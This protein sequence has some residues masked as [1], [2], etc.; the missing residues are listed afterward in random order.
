M[1]K[2]SITHF[3]IALLALVFT[4]SA[5]VKGEFDVPPINIPEFEG[6]ANKT[7]ADLKASYAWVLDSIEEDIIIT[8]KVVGNDESGNIY[9][10]LIIQD[11]TGGIELQ[12]DR[13]SM[14]TEFK[15]GQVV[16]VKCR[17]MY[18]GDYNKLIQLGGK[19]EGKIGR[20][21][22]A[23]IN[24]HVFRDSLPGTVP[25]ATLVPV[26]PDNKYISMLVK[27]ENVH[28]EDPG[29]IWATQDASATNRNLLDAAGNALIVRTSQ[30]ASFCNEKIPAGSGTVTGILSIFGTDYQLTIRDTND[31]KGFV[32]APPVYFEE[33]FA[34]GQGAFTTQSITGT[35]VW[36]WDSKY[37]MK[38]SGYSGGNKEN[39]DWLI[40][41]PIDLRTAPAAVV[42]FDQAI[43]YGTTA[44][45]PINHTLW[46]SKNYTGGAPST[47]TW[48]KVTIPTFPPGNN[49]AFLA[50][51]TCTLPAGYAGQNS[52]R[53]AFKYQ[54]TTTEST[55]WEIKNVK[56]ARN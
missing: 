2:N 36:I 34:A 54:S 7:I 3:S 50:S 53:I 26:K 28:F 31:L 25:P 30:Y 23:L 15:L 45:I 55:T 21:P 39:E 1:K 6:T 27:L 44:N 10:K 38:M 13:T 5:C 42:T 24:Q 41:P 37:G 11:Q 22:D 52:V 18:I 19:F 29:K 47:A 48:E 51:G 40:S 12:L 32:P 33:P 20:L 43:N 17:G 8:G 14:Y 35:Q 4:L 46:V 49:W 16:F 56:V 9:K